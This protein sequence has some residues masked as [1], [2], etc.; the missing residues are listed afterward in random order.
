MTYSH[1]HK[2]SCK[3]FV[4]SAGLFFASSVAALAAN[5]FQVDVDPASTADISHGGSDLLK[6]LEDLANSKNQ[7]SVLS[8]QAWTGKA[9][10]YGL[11][12]ALN[13]LSNETGTSLTISSSLTGLNKTFTGATRSEVDDK[14]EDWFKKDGSEE[15]AKLLKEIA[16]RSPAALTDGNPN[17]STA[18]M[19]AAAFDQFGFQEV[20]TEAESKESATDAQ[21]GSKSQ[22]VDKSS[23]IGMGIGMNSGFFELDS[24]AGKI[25]GSKT[26]VSVPFKYQM[27]E[28]LA[29]S[30]GLPLEYMEIEDAKVYGAGVQ[31][32]I[33]W[34]PYRMSKK[35]DFGW[36]ITPFAG[37]N[38]RGSKE[39]ATG[40]LLSQYGG[41]SSIDY[42]MNKHLILSMANQM[43]FFNSIPVTVGGM[44]LDSKIDQVIFR[45]GFKAGIPFWERWVSENY[46]IDTRFANKAAIE[47]YE[48]LGTSMSYRVTQ[49]MYLKVALNYDV[50]DNF[51]GWGAG[52]SSAWSF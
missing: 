35:D 37:A 36:A 33:T 34:K 24:P 50:G 44:K 28:S 19:A 26:S 51:Q 22:S 17:A 32:G 4:R 8:T 5:L 16:K 11:P 30:F 45:N 43:S 10:L 1:K 2:R 49:S 18:T 48:T 21:S 6:L 46:I 3:R 20:S 29:L 41:T 39:A 25:K 9:T 42:R 14:L 23:F 47:S 7:F 31:T 12:N 27:N 38:V 40:T 15:I 52:L 13:V